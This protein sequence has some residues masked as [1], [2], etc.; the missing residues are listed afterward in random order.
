MTDRTT[1]IGPIPVQRALPHLAG[2]RVLVLSRYDVQ[3]PRAGAAET[4]LHETARRWVAAGATVTL[5]TSRGAG[6]PRRTDLDGVDVRRAGGTPT[7]HLRTALRLLRTAHLYDVVVDVRHGVPFFAPLFAPAVPV[8]QVVH[9]VDG[10]RSPGVLRRLLDGPVATRV[11]DRNRSVAV[12]ASTRQEMR[13]RLQVDGLVDVVPPG[14]AVPTDARQ[15][16]LVPTVVVVSGFARHERVDLLID[17][18]V[19]ARRHLPSLRV[20]VVGDGPEH[21]RLQRHVTASGRDGWVTFRG[22]LPAAERD[23]L[24]GSAWLTTCTS[25]GDGWGAAV[26]AAA[27]LGVPCLA[28]RSPGTRDA[29]IDGRTGRL[30]DPAGGSGALAR[31]LVLM[32][33]ALAVPAVAETYAAECRRWA[34]CFT[35]ERSADMLA[36]AVLAEVRRGGAR[37]TEGDRRARIRRRVRSDVTTVARFTHPGPHGLLGLLRLTDEIAADGPVFT[38]VLHGTDDADARCLL[39]AIGAEDIRVR[40]AN[41]HELLGGPAAIDGP[42]TDIPV[43]E[44]GAAAALG[45]REAARTLP[46]QRSDEA[47]TLAAF[48]RRE[49]RH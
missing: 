29:V 12:S 31:E 11:Y 21:A 13:R 26:L 2:V 1:T 32:V 49:P 41:R 30:V 7:V 27:A 14:T 47:R 35:W 46:L 18:V 5:L 20:D 42:A 16:A 17:A 23:A 4:H 8:V 39:T 15:R 45:R 3:H 25:D 19:A 38:A 36:A 44:Q 43:P 48:L 22:R 6:R 28:L 34:G 37:P 33:E 9:E 24:L 10:P 40:P